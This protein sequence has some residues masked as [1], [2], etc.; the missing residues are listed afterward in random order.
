MVTLTGRGDDR[1]VSPVREHTRK[2][3]RQ[4]LRIAKDV[5]L[6]EQEDPKFTALVRASGGWSIRMMTAKLFDRPPNDVMKDM[7]TGEEKELICQK[8][9]GMNWRHSCHTSRVRGTVMVL[10]KTWTTLLTT[11]P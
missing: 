4:F 11:T 7:G 8:M 6:C 3:E 2:K 9:N 1:H 5:M 10:R